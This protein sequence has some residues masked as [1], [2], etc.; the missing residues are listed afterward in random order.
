MAQLVIFTDAWGPK[1]GGINSFNMDF[2]KALG[3]LLSPSVRV[4]CVVLECNADEVTDA[5]RHKVTLVSIGRSKDHG[6]F[7][8]SRAADV[9]EVLNKIE[10]QLSVLWWVGHD[11]V[12]GELAVRVKKQSQQ[13]KSAVIHHMSYIDYFS[14]KHGVGQKAQDK[15]DRQ[16]RIFDEADRCFGVGPL[17]RDR[18]VDMLSVDESA[19]GMII[20]GLADIEPAPMP[21]KF[22]A[23]VFGRLD[24]ENDRIKQ[25]WLAVAGFSSAWKEANRLASPL[26]GL[27][28]GVSLSVIGIASGGEEEANLRTYSQQRAERV[29]PLIALPYDDRREQVFEQLRKCSLAMML[30]W[31]EGFGLTGWEAIAAEV[32]LIVSRNS[33]LYQLVDS[34]LGGSGT[35][36]LQ[37]ID[38]RGK[39]GEDVGDN[40]RAEDEA[41]VVRAILKIAGDTDRAKKD[42]KRLLQNLRREGCTWQQSARV[43]AEAL[44]LPVPPSASGSLVPTST[45]TPVVRALVKDDSGAVTG[46]VLE[47]PQPRWSPGRGLA[48]SQL[49]RSEEA[50]V[51]FHAMRRPL[52]E[53]VVT[54]ATATNVPDVTMQLRVGPGG[55]GKTRLLLEMCR[56]LRN[57]GWCAGFLRSGAKADLETSFRKLVQAQKQT[58]V[59]V[60]YAEAR[61]EEIVHLVVAGQHASPG[62]KVRIM[63]LAREAGDWWQQLLTARKDTEAFFAGSAVTGPYRMPPISVNRA[64][65][66]A[67]F[68]DSL[69]AFAQRLGLDYAEITPPDLS[70]RHFEDV[71]FIH[72]SALAALDGERPETESGLLDATLRHERDYWEQAAQAQGLPKEVHAGIAQGMAVLTLCDG[73]RTT[74]DARARLAVVPRLRSMSPSVRDQV[75]QVLRGFYPE[76]GGIDALR[77][78]LLGETLVGQEL[79][80]DDEVLDLLLGNTSDDAI[81]TSALLVLARLARRQPSHAVWLKTALQRHLNLICRV[82]VP[83]TM[84]IGEPLGTLIVDALN[85]AASKRQQAPAVEALLQR[86]PAK[87]VA[88]SDVALVVA[89]LH[90]ERLKRKGSPTGD[91]QKSQL[92]LA[93][94]N[95]SYRLIESRRE[96]EALTVLESSKQVLNEQ[97]ILGKNKQRHRQAEIENLIGICLSKLGRYED[98]LKSTDRALSLLR[99]LASMSNCS[100]EQLAGTLTNRANRLCEL[101]RYD[102]TLEASQEAVDILKKHTSVHPNWYRANLAGSLSNLGNHLLDVGR[103]QDGLERAEEALKIRQELAIADPDAYSVDLAQSLNNYANNLHG[104]GRFRE[105]LERAEEALKIYRQLAE[106]RPD[107]YRLGLAASLSNLCHRLWCVGR[108]QEGLKRAE[109]ALKIRQ[110]LAEAGPNEYRA[111]LAASLSLLGD[112]LRDLGRYQEG[113]ECEE[114]ALKIY[115]ELAVTW[116]DAHRANLAQSQR[117]LAAHLCLV[118][119][120]ELAVPSAQAAVTVFK[121]LAKARPAVHLASLASALG[122]LAEAYVM[123]QL[124]AEGRS[125]ALEALE[126]YTSL[127]TQ[128]GSSVMWDEECAWVHSFLATAYDAL[129]DRDLLSTAALAGLRHLN[130]DLQ[131]R[132]RPMTNLLLKCAK[133]LVLGIS[134]DEL[135]RQFPFVGQ[136]LRLVEQD[137]ST[138][139]GG[140]LVEAKPQ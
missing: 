51:P 5:A 100:P 89:Q 93:Q 38:V 64:E 43:F 60:D 19:V 49:L 65:R 8:A 18:L 10:P 71:L 83:V 54:W 15:F 132:P 45:S 113:L 1:Y 112:C 99:Q 20:P 67:V 110:E 23:V 17:L 73:T 134:P 122:Q 70:A 79:V 108:Y 59:V 130:S 78:D 120:A 102:E 116:P 6:L 58:L 14:Y 101:G 107:A 88:L 28:T 128:R 30:S 41:Q 140:G 68:Q 86:L 127:I 129:G 9:V 37:E 139:A 46:S 97:S 106:A 7:E 56:Q 34:V 98:A 105:G 36:C 62:H 90:L 87:T 96:K 138:G 3:M 50:C 95:F 77:P 84:A 82:A 22:S 111:E 40:F 32:P 33:G 85:I 131:H 16:K 91:K 94:M 11:T 25:G 31:H 92:V 125:A 115:Q 114:E 47:L 103:Y 2:A 124:Y 42:A 137:D 109:E 136:A 29:F 35:G 48:I 123:H 104:V 69:V 24:A 133:R 63:L 13:G 53:Q 75:L 81:R 118:G 135:N 57:Q 12:T 117:N 121:E 27:K 126:V 26:A 80:R 72:M 76:G 55:S 52:L 4:I 119:K 21:K 61:L 44:G 66:E 39:D 74:A